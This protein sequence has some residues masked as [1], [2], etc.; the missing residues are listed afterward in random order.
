MTTTRPDWIKVCVDYGITLL[1][2]DRTPLDPAVLGLPENV[3]MILKDTHNIFCGISNDPCDEE[4]EDFINA[5]FA[6]AVAVKAAWPEVAVWVEDPLRME[7]DL[8][9][10]FEVTP[11]MVASGQKPRSDQPV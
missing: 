9:V 11:E 7:Y 3:Q 2:R 6:A 8:P 5:E 10:A 4:V 1:D